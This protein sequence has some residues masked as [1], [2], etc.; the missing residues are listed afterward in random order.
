MTVTS[1]YL[2]IQIQ[3]MRNVL[4]RL[5]MWRSWVQSQKVMKMELDNGVENANYKT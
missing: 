2:Q 5:L 1:I 3:L 4:Y